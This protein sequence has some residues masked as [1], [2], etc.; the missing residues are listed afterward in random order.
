MSLRPGACVVDATVG[1]GG[2]AKEI[3]QN[4][5]PGGRLIGID[6]DETALGMAGAALKDFQGSF[7]LVRD[8]FRNI[9]A[10]LSHEGVGAIDAVLL[11]LGVS[12]Y[13][14]EGPERGFSI[15]H[16]ARL[17][18][19]MDSREPLTAH[20]VVNKYSE[21]DLALIIERYGEERFARK[22]AR[23]IVAA[24]ERK[25]IETTHD[26]VSVVHR[27][28]GG[29]YRGH[30]IDPAT[31]TFQGIRIFVND[32]LKAL[33]E[34]LKRAV[35]LLRKDG[36]IAVISFHSLEDRIVKNTFKEYQKQGILNIIT[37][38]PLRPSDAEVITNPRAR[39]AKMRVAQKG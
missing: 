2:H 27:A 7:T 15:R 28:V 26:L 14:L 25:T 18:M 36:R 20:Q 30:R 8:N 32:E 13:Q 29:R 33:E 38:K 21:R 5:L 35:P 24:R 4:I 9:D 23:A 11:D 31:R 3:I 34:G 39:S 22:I 6:A 10:I 37:K 17:D 16:E 1:G 19:R 12:S